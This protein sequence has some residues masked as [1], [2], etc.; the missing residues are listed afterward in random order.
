MCYIQPTDS[1]LTQTKLSHMVTH[2]DPKS[3]LSEIS[4]VMT[5]QYLSVE[6]RPAATSCRNRV[7]AKDVS[8]GL[9][10]KDSL[11]SSDIHHFLSVFSLPWKK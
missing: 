5:I 2:A 1:K 8:A 6:S 10:R 3:T 4:R 11:E 9:R 7:K